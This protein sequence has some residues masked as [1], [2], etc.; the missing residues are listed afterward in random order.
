MPEFVIKVSIP[1]PLDVADLERLEDVVYDELTKKMGCPTST[2]S[3]GIGF[4]DV[5]AVYN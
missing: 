4:T 2:D 1:R 5:E 3:E